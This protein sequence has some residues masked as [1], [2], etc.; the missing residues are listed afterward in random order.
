MNPPP[1]VVHDTSFHHRPSAR[2]RMQAHMHDLQSPFRRRVPLQELLGLPGHCRNTTLAVLGDLTDLGSWPA[3]LNGE[4][5]MSQTTNCV[6]ATSLL[7]ATWRK[8]RHSNP[9]GDCVELAE[10]TGGKIA[11]RNSRHPSGP[12][13]IFARPEMAAFIHGAEAGKFDETTGTAYS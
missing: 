8:S 4:I 11:V 5:Y 6:P 10:L 1:E 2:M 7:A 12:A 13:L 9:R 3:E